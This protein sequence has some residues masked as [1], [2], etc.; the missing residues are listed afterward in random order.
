MTLLTL[1][2]SVCRQLGLPQPNSAF[3]ATDDMVE[4]IV[5]LLQE[6]G[7]DLLRDHDWSV[8]TVQRDFTATGFEVQDEPPTVSVA[9]DRFAQNCSLW[10][11]GNK[12]TLDGPK[13]PMEWQRI[14]ID[15]VGTLHRWW[16]MLGG[17]IHI[18]PIPDVTET[19]RYTYVTKNWIRIDLGDQAS[20]ISAWDNDSNTSLMPERLLKLSTIWRWKQVKGLSYEEDMATF[21]REKIRHIARDRGPRS[22]STTLWNRDTD[23]SD[24]WLPWN[25]T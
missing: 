7:D 2:Q 11:I 3:S 24:R 21:E 15:D 22:I 14:T 9:F 25:I 8:L 17:V 18:L 6:A 16:T 5:I 20:D 23:W 10:D 4:Q 13:T 1:T 12:W 19:F